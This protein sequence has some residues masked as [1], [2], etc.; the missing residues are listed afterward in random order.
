[1]AKEISIESLYVLLSGFITKQE[2]FITKQEAFNTQQEIHNNKT[3]N[4]FASIREDLRA[5]RQEE[6]ANHNLSHRM[7]TQAFEGISDIRSELDESNAP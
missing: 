7:I 4:S 6:Q 1:M 3:D 2:A 5:F